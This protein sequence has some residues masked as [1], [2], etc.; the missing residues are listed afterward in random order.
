MDEGLQRVTEK[1]YDIATPEAADSLVEALEDTEPSLLFLA[2][3]ELE[4]QRSLHLIPNP[5]ATLYEYD[6]T[7]LLIDYFKAIENF[8]RLRM[9]QA[10]CGTSSQSNASLARMTLGQ[11]RVELRTKPNCY[12]VSLAHFD[13]ITQLLSNYTSQHRNSKVHHSPVLD[14]RIV[15]E[16]RDDTYRILL[17]LHANLR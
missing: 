14:M 9:A 4:F 5:E 8:L 17:T 2:S 6:L 7:P 12:L 15:E 11:L 3:A 13:E 10:S 1:L 16:V